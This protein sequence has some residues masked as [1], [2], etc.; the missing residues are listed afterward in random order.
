MWNPKC[1]MLSIYPLDPSIAKFVKKEK[2]EKCT[3]TP[4]LT[5]IIREKNGTNYLIINTNLTN[6]YKEVVCCWAPVIRPKPINLSTDKK[7][8]SK[9]RFVNSYY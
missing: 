1:H 5:R 3:Y 4:L 8:D 7:F 2:F 9:I 6:K